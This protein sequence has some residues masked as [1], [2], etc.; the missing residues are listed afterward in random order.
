MM[1][2]LKDEQR[3]ILAGLEELQAAGNPDWTATLTMW[4]LQFTG[5]QLVAAASPDPAQRAKFEAV[6]ADRK[7][8]MDAILARIRRMRRKAS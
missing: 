6:L 1:A 5:M 7:R 8:V 2:Q 3:D 4:R